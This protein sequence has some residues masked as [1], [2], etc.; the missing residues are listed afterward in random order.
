MQFSVFMTPKKKKK[1]KRKDSQGCLPP[2]WDSSAAICINRASCCRSDSGTLSLRSGPAGEWAVGPG[3]RPPGT[4]ADPGGG[5]PSPASK[6]RRRL[7][8]VLRLASVGKKRGGEVRSV[9][10]LVIL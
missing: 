1:K 4:G 5:D 2:C 3:V 9:L 7:G 10:V 8:V 6:L